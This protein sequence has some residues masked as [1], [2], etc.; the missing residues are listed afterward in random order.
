MSLRGTLGDFGIADIFQLIGHQAKTGVLLLKDRDFEVRIFFVDGNVVK[1]EQSSRDK[2]DLLGNIMVRGRV[3]E[4]AQLD[5]ALAIQQRTMRRLGDILVESGAVD[6]AT[7]REFA[8]LQ[9]TETIYRLF[10]WKTGTYEFVAQP[11][12]YDEQSYEP[13]RSENILMEGFRMV[14]EWPAVRKVIPSSSLTFRVLKA[15]PAED[16][17]DEDDDILAGLGDAL[18]GEG[19][20]P[21]PRRVGHAERHVFAFIAPG[22]SVAEIIDLSRMGEFE[23]TKALAT[24]VS[25]GV[26]AIEAAASPDEPA[27][28]VWAS[29]WTAL[30][31]F[32]AR[33][34]FAAV[35][36]LV[37]GGTLWQATTT[38]AGVLSTTPGESALAAMREAQAVMQAEK[39]RRALGIHLVE[40]AAHPRSLDELVDLG[41]IEER[42]LTF[43]FGTPWVYERTE[44]G[45][46][47]SRP[48]R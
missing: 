37:V 42:D 31:A 4:Q 12:D 21:A 5:Q 36:A 2:A 16:A 11:V 44:T 1:A 27:R 10:S 48:V 38:T 20:G 15:L 22:R 26:I 8:R 13:I 30:R 46:R 17:V 19:S 45:Y 34:A 24:L 29:L 47:L 39:L 43:P 33:L 3:L 25:N 9:T 18:G 35:T 7:L 23:T 6:R 32:S 28:A 14:D 41:L 40:R